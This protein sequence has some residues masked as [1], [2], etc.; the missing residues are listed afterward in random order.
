MDTPSFSDI[1]VLWRQP[2]TMS[3]WGIPY[4]MRPGQAPRD[5]W[6]AREQWCV[7]SAD[8]AAGKG[9]L[10]T[11]P[12]A[13]KWIWLGSP[14]WWGSAPKEAIAQMEAF[15]APL[16]ARNIVPLSPGEWADIKEP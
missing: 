8:V 4:P 7:K 9:P 6:E 5:L 12:A 2:D 16:K 13:Y 3:L 15:L 10:L 14:G 11:M 1:C